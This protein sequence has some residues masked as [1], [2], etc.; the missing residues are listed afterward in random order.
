MVLASL[1]FGT[2]L[3]LHAQLPGNAEISRPPSFSTPAWSI[4]EI[5]ESY[6]WIP[7]LWVT[8]WGE[9]GQLRWPV[10]DGVLPVGLG[11]D[12]LPQVSLL[13]GLS[14]LRLPGSTFPQSV[15]DARGSLGYTSGP[16][17]SVEVIP[18]WSLP[19]RP[20][21]EL[22]YSAGAYGFSSIA[23][24]HGQPL[25]KSLTVWLEGGDAAY[26]GYELGA[27]TRAYSIRTRALYQLNP[28]VAF[29]LS[30][31]KG[32]GEQHLP[33]PLVFVPF[34]GFLPERQKGT[35]VRHD[36][37][38]DLLLSRGLAVKAGF[39]MLRERWEWGLPPLTSSLPDRLS[40]SLIYAATG[41]GTWSA[42]ILSARQTISDRGAHEAH[43]CEFGART[44]R[45]IPIGSG[46]KAVFAA[47][48]VQV[49]QRRTPEGSLQ[50]VWSP[51]GYRLAARVLREPF[52]PPAI[53]RIRV[54]G[55]ADATLASRTAAEVAGERQ[56]AWGTL[57]VELSRSL[58]GDLPTPSPLGQGGSP[59]ACRP[60]ET[61][62][63]SLVIRTPSV[64]GFQLRAKGDSYTNPV[65]GY[66][67][68]VLRAEVSYTDTLFSGDLPCRL[69]LQVEGSR[70]MRGALPSGIAQFLPWDRR[71]SPYWAFTALISARYRD[72]LFYAEL[73][74][75]PPGH[76]EILPALEAEPLWASWGVRVVLWD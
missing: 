38:L 45:T 30:T 15:T 62:R 43:W 52:V 48:L 1:W 36:G 10:L 27:S 7:G 44:S 63:I 60:W 34:S 57:V 25:G 65:P 47:G 32:V 59:W 5:G 64:A 29:R 20:R 31:Q 3:D 75:C 54:S 58:Y 21:S 56:G 22:S 49:A 9:R 35:F 76:R 6:C 28:K 26:D 14:D 41:G 69:S 12:G 23:A 50:I 72:A 37:R 53:S 4:D 66:P 40:R 16:L 74:W 8:R 67:S 51:A 13:L 70:W 17:P 71:P 73:S 61:E 19:E 46:A 2:S 55:K 11:V 42:E 24:Q 68:L 33:H 18:R 39:Q